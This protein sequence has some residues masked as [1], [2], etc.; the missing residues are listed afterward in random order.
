MMTIYV[1]LLQKELEGRLS[2]TALEYIE[3]VVN[4]GQRISRLIDGLQFTRLGGMAEIKPVPVDA[5]MAV[6]EA[7][8]DL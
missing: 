5:E 2:E 7:L 4:G 3:N 8:G 6:R 1:Q